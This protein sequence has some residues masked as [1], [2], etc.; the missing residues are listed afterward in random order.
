M[1]APEMCLGLRVVVSVYQGFGG[2]LGSLERLSFNRSIDSNRWAIRE[3]IL[4][5]VEVFRLSES[6]TGY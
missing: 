5:D 2:A 6:A 4:M 3:E 1:F